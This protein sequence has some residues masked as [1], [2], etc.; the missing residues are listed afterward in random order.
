[1]AKNLIKNFAQ[2]SKADTEIAG[3]KGAS[4]GEMTQAGIPVPEGFVILSN[5]FDRFLEETDL[6]VEIDAVLDTVNIKEVHTVENAS[7]K[8][9]AM[10]ISKEMPEDI[11]T[12]I[13]K[14]YKNLNSKYVAVR[15]SATSEDS[16]S[17]A[18]AGQ[19]DSFLNTTKETLLENVKKCWASLFT[20]RA[21]FYR[22]E[23]KLSKDN[24]SVAVVVQKM[25]DSEES[26]IAFSVHPVTQDENHII[27]EAGFG[28]GE[29][30]VS[31]SITPDS[32]VVDK[33]GFNIL[34]INVNEQTKALYKKPKGGNEWKNLGEKGKK[35]VLTKKEIIELSKLI[36]KIENHYGFPCDIEWAK[37]K[38]KFY[39][40]QSRPITTL[41]PI[42]LENKIIK[43]IKNMKWEKWLER[44]F[45]AFTLSL[46]EG[47]STKNS[48]ESIGLKNV[49]PLPQLF[50][51]GFWYLNKES[52]HKID[53]QIGKYL[54]NKGM[55]FITSNLKEFKKN[56][57]RRIKLIIKSKKP[58][59]KKFA[60]IFNILTKACTF[61]WL[62]HGVE[63]YFDNKLKLEVP[64]YIKKDI[65]KFIG[66]A[67][68]PKKKNANA[69]LDELMRTDISNKEIAEKMGWVKIRDGFSQPFTETEIKE[70]R[71]NLGQ[72]HTFSRVKI[73]VE[74]RPLFNQV[75][76]LVFFRTERT[77]VFYYLYFLSRPVLKELAEKH[78]IKFTNMTFYRAKSFIGGQTEKFTP[79]CSFAF[80]GDNVLFQN[81]PIIL[82]DKSL[83]QDISGNIA[84]TGKVKGVVKIVKNT[85]ELSKVKKGDIL[86]T[87][88]TFPSFILA[89]NRASAFVTDE[90][91][92]TCHAAIVAREM[93]K[94]CII[95]TKNATR[96]LSDYDLI[97]VDANQGIVK[98]LKKFKK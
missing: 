80:D 41:S 98:I 74:L 65:D 42:S 43:N 51:Q 58:L 47:S 88:M 17:A 30:I 3:G 32:Y 50:Q 31:G 27:I 91:G 11:K 67:S 15:S 24:I 76:E 6:N 9:Q 54:E 97:E 22:F 90:G 64:K 72:I 75:Q 79:Q 8:I 46:F 82:E 25:V 83:K 20:P 86:V 73:P 70:M 14:F 38:D 87:Q 40:V 28:L 85:K 57:E 94:P 77:D 36:I 26:G 21:I 96:L 66:D 1:M 63:S 81:D 45:Y 53:I 2:I 44:P 13:L 37:E 34:D 59:E 52:M 29:A 7:E 55:S 78:N 18:W 5:A 48:F 23:K 71:K 92:I 68:F 12:E 10:I 95:G 16:A 35:Q 33:Q 69:V 62:A 60:E 39:I 61:I 4:L 93:R 19:L 84:Y 89:M 49:G 56:S